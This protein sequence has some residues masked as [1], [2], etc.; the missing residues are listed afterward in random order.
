MVFRYYPESDILYIGLAA[1][2][3]TESGKVASNIVL[4]YDLNN[5]IIGID[6]KDASRHIAMSK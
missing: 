5:Q 1:G 4:D 6:V 2:V 3:S